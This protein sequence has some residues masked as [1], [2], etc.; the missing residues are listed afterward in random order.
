MDLG[1]CYIL[2]CAKLSAKPQ[3]YFADWGLP[4]S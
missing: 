3:K 1:F 4:V 2:F